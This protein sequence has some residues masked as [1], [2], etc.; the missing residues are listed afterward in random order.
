MDVGRGAGKWLWIFLNISIIII[1]GNNKRL[2]TLLGDFSLVFK[3]PSVPQN[4]SLN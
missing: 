2:N 4:V 1:L 3:L